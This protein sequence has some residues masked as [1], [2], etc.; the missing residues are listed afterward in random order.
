MILKLSSLLD[1]ILYQVDKPLVLLQDEIHHIEDYISLEK[2]RFQEGLK[3]T[4]HKNLIYDKLEIAPMLLL[5]FV[6]NAFKHGSQIDGV[7]KVNIN[8]KVN[9]NELNFTIENSAIKKEDSKKGIG[10]DNIIKRLK[11]LY[12]EEHFLEILQ[13][14]KLYKVTLKIPIKNEE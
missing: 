7:V 13:E 11:M 4:F 3:I 6:E 12:Q 1:Y 10:L 14:E 5:P 8:L 2:L 9:E